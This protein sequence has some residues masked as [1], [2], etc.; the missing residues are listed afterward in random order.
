[1]DETKTFRAE[2]VPSSKFQVKDK[3]LTWN[4]E[5]GTWNLELG[6]WNLELGT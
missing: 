4:L 5:L 2:T 3:F 1:L 6:T